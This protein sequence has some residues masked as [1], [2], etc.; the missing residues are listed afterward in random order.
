MAN[1]SSL[2]RTVHSYPHSLQT[3]T[4]ALP[5]QLGGLL[6]INAPR[7]A[8][9]HRARGAL[10]VRCPGEV[11]TPDPRDDLSR[12]NL[13][14]EGRDCLPCIIY[15][16]SMYMLARSLR[17]RALD[18]IRGPSLPLCR[19]ARFACLAERSAKRANGDS[20]DSAVHQ[21]RLNT[22]FRLNFRIFRREPFSVRHYARGRAR[23]PIS[24]YL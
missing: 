4:R 20:L 16:P 2:Q 18:G 17:T 12:A 10:L 14:F 24:L 22:G 23:A 8:A 19:V 9:I 3:Q 11:G 7:V 21:R 6:I 15:V 13:I 1:A 5:S